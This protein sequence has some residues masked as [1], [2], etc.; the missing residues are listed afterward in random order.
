[1]RLAEIDA[2]VKEAAATR[3]VQWQRSQ[4]EL[5]AMP[6]VR[7]SLDCAGYVGDKVVLAEAATN[8]GNGKSLVHFRASGLPLVAVMSN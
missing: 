6:A 5:L 4:D 7:L 1:V 2:E 8:I 3:K